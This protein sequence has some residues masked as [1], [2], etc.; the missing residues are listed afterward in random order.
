MGT[1]LFCQ[2]LHTD[3]ICPDVYEPGCI[4]NLLTDKGVSTGY[5]WTNVGASLFDGMGLS[6]YSEPSPKIPKPTP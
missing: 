2:D 4:D 3:P 6:Y 1:T 5:G